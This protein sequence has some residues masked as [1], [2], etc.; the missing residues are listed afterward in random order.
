MY[1]GST[2]TAQVDGSSKTAPLQGGFFFFF[3]FFFL[4][5]YFV[6]QYKKVE[7]QLVLFFYLFHIKYI[8]SLKAKYTAYVI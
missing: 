7:K 1:D 8:K 4:V 3:F 5:F 2:V 6:N